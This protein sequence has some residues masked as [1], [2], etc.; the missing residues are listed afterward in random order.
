MTQ[1]SLNLRDGRIHGSVTLAYLLLIEGV[2]Q[3]VSGPVK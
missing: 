1:M 2:K 3:S